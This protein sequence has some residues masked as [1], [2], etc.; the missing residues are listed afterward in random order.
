MYDYIHF[1]GEERE[2]EERSY[3]L[4]IFQLQATETISPK[5]Y[6]NVLSH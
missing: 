4:E 2:D 3:E 5:W 6:G 1:I